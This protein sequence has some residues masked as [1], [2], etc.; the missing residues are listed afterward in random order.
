MSGTYM[1]P[2]NADSSYYY[3]SLS[4]YTLWSINSLKA[5]TLSALVSAVFPAPRGGTGI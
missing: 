3:F 1:H 4:V 2:V 5:R